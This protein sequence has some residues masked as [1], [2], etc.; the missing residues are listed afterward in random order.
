[1][2]IIQVEVD[3][4]R[5]LLLKVEWVWH[6][7]GG[8]FRRCPSCQAYWGTKYPANAPEYEAK[9]EHADDCALNNMLSHIGRE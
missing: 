2:K 6:D 3:E 9:E 7:F 5:A 1:M 4:L 8:G